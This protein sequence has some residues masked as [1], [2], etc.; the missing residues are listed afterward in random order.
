MDL[1]NHYSKLSN[2]SSPCFC[3][4]FDDCVLGFPCAPALLDEVVVPKPAPYRGCGVTGGGGM[5][6]AEKV[7]GFMVGC[8]WYVFWEDSGGAGIENPEGGWE[9]GDWRG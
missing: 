1:P 7:F 8:C 5:L 6:K 4:V 2:A 3:D 9:G